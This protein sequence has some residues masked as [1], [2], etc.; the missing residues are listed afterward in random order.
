MKYLPFKNTYKLS[1]AQLEQIDG[2]AIR[3]TDKLQHIDVGELPIS[4]Y[5]QKYLSRYLS[6][7]QFYMTVYAQLMAKAV[8]TLKKPVAQSIFVDYGG[9]S[10][11]LS[12]LAIEMGFSKVLYN[13]IYDVSVADAQVTGR[14]LNLKATHYIC[15]D[16]D[17]LVT[18][19]N[20]EKIQA[21]VLCSMDVLEHIYDPVLW[22]SKARQIKGCFSIV[23]LTSANSANP[24]VKKRL[25][26]L[27]H[28]AEWI[29][30]QKIEGWKERDS[31][32]A[33]VELRKNIIRQFNPQLDNFDVNQL[34][35]YT[36]GLRIDDIEKAT[37]R[38]TNN[39]LLPTKIKHP[40]NTCDP[41]TGNWSENLIDIHQFRVD[42]SNMGY[43]IRITNSFYS[44]SENK[45]LNLIKMLINVVLRHTGSGMLCISPSF[46]VTAVKK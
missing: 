12:L 7:L 15:G 29:G 34:A 20:S 3:L 19:L 32:Q 17:E 44:F 45:I 27:Q 40:S 13:D 43:D 14:Q 38:F 26:K 35:K 25:M 6:H 9:G 22:F 39:G 28:K 46:T 42:L 11:L 16:I 23:F 21:D 1:V 37:L 4:E 18:F 30:E 41:Y 33:F 31:V 36:R 10:G 24:F 8:K 5:N 2:A